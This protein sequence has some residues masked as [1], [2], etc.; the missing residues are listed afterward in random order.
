MEMNYI[1]ALEKFNDA[2]KAFLEGSNSGEFSYNESTEG[3]V[4]FLVNK[5][6]KIIEFFV[7]DIKFKYGKDKFNYYYLER[8]LLNFPDAII[9][10]LEKDPYC[11]LILAKAFL[12]LGTGVNDEFMK[13]VDKTDHF[14]LLCLKMAKALND[15]HGFFANPEYID[16]L[17]RANEEW[18]EEKIREE[19]DFWREM[20]DLGVT[21]EDVYD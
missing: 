18:Q 13:N 2:C 19:R 15:L 9:D 7:N 8:T 3:K 5:E 16:R 6:E 21:P 17:C 11:L 1:N 12:E 4:G 20:A 10:H 14:R